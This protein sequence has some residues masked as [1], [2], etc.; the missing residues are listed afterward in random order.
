MR[1]YIYIG[2]IPDVGGYGISVASLTE[3]EAMKTLKREYYDWKKSRHIDKTFKEA[4]EY[5]GGGVDKIEL[6]KGY[7]DNFNY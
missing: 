7:F 1:K 4:L 3:E 2:L 5:Y 6:N